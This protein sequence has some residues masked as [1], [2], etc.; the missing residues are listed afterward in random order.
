MLSIIIITKDEQKCLPRLL[1]SIQAQDFSDKEIIVSDAGS[2]D[3]TIK[4]AKEFGCRIVKGGYPSIG[5]NHGAKVANG[6]IFLFLDADIILPPNFLRKNI[7]EFKKR[8]LGTATTVYIPLSEKISDR[9]LFKLYDIWAKSMQFFYPHSGGF[10]IFCR[11]DIFKKTKGFDEKLLIAE[12]HDFVNRSTAYG[13]FRI[14][15]SMPILADVRRL[16]KEGRLNLTKKYIRGAAFRIMKGEAYDPPFE[17]ELHGGVEIQKE[18]EKQNNH[19][20]EKH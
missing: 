17:Y 5:R 6:D 16:E 7:E 12:D 11:R 3:N 19:G 1:R 2:T 8:K 9:T 4:I 13:K 18:A 10:C 14:L 20:D 15:K